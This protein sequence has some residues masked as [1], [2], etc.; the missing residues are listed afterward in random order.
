MFVFISY[1]DS[2]FVCFPLFYIWSMHAILYW[3]Y[4]VFVY[5][6]M[7]RLVGDHGEAKYRN[8]AKDELSKEIVLVRSVFNGDVDKMMIKQLGSGG[9]DESN[10]RAA[11]WYP[12]SYS[13]IDC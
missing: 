8:H 6:H 12:V 10:E 4:I 11:A 5:V 13:G 2:E 3:C 7:C 1:W 9:E